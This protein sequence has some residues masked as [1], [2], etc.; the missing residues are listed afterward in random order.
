MSTNDVTTLGKPAT[1][2]RRRPRRREEA[3]RVMASVLGHRDANP[4][5][6]P[7]TGHPNPAWE[8]IPSLAWECRQ[9]S[10]SEPLGKSQASFETSFDA[11][12]VVKPLA[13][14]MR[15]FPEV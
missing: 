9:P 8:S 11:R 12:R 3:D 14:V 10:T 15:A 1:I 4:V 13:M 6:R 2:P 5:H 7:S